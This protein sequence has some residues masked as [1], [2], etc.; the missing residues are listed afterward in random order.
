MAVAE[1]TVIYDGQVYKKGETIHDLGS[2]ECTEVEGLKRSY[3]GLSKDV[4]KLPK[5]P[6]LGTGSLALCLDTGDFYRYHNPTKT[7]YKL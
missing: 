6:T 1:K 2:F 4:S 5:Y 3:E 7:W